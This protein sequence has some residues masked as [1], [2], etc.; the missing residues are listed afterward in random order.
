MHFVI[1]AH[2]KQ[3]IHWYFASVFN[4]LR[5]RLFSCPT[6]LPIFAERL[7]NPCTHDRVVKR[8]S[9]T[10]PGLTETS[11][12]MAMVRTEKGHLTVTSLTRSSID[13]AKMALSDSIRSVFELAG[14]KYT[15]SGGYS[16]WT[17]VLGTPMIQILQD[18]Y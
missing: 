8:M 10:L 7:G 3:R 2:S 4:G 6:K 17:P 1:S 15:T 14:A 9:D 5:G 13:S 11:T 16:G 18:T 12:N